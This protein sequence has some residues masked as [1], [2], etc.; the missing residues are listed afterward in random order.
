MGCFDRSTRLGN[1]VVILPWSE[2]THYCNFTFVN[3]PAPSSRL[4]GPPRSA[5]V[6]FVPSPAASPARTSRLAAAGFVSSL[7]S[8]SLPPAP[9]RALGF[10][11]FGGV[12]L[13]LWL[14]S[15]FGLRR[16]PR[17][18]RLYFRIFAP[19]YARRGYDNSLQYYM[20]NK[21]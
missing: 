2:N 6:R 11:C 7:S 12:A 19:R 3:S 4:E 8:A 10:P 1:T 21:V 18:L 15:C 13:C 16:A 20:F 9:P 17:G 14:V 5:F